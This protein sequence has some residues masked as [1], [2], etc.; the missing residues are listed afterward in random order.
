M[1]HR[2]HFKQIVQVW[3]QEAEK[4]V[5]FLLPKPVFVCVVGAPPFFFF[6]CCFTTDCRDIFVNN[7][8]FVV[9]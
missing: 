2:K 5:R 7:F 1:Y 6:F 9:E 4:G 8:I 3:E